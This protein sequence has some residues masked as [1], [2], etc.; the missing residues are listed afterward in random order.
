MLYKVNKDY[1]FE[2]AKQIFTS[3]CNI[4]RSSRVRALIP[5][6]LQ[7]KSKVQQDQNMKPLRALDSGE[8]SLGTTSSYMM[9]VD[10]SG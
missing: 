6:N 8:E 5:R 4:Y 10:T 9:Y 1:G 3:G 7:E 2:T